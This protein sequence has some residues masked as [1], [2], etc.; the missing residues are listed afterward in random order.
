MPEKQ[1]TYL[2]LEQQTLAQIGRS[3]DSWTAFLELSG[4]LYKYTFSEQL[5]IYAQRPDATACASY[6]IW[7]DTMKRYIK[8]GAKG[9][10]LT[11]DK[12]GQMELRHVFDIADTGTR[13]ISKSP[14][15]WSCEPVHM[16]LLSR[17]LAKIYPGIDIAESFEAQV[18]QCVN[19]MARMYFEAH[20]EDIQQSVDGSLLAGY[21]AANIETKFCEAA[22]V[23]IA[24]TLLSR[25]DLKPKELYVH[26]DFL[27]VFECRGNQM[28]SHLGGA[29]SR[30]SGTLLRQFEGVIKQY[31]KERRNDHEQNNLYTAR[32]LSNSQS[33]SNDTGLPTPAEIR[34]DAKNIPERA[35]SGNVSVSAHHGDAVSTDGR[36]RSGSRQAPGGDDAQAHGSTGSDRRAKTEGSHTMGRENEQHQGTGGGDHPNGA[37]VQLNLFSKELHDI[38]NEDAGAAILPSPAS[39]S[40]SEAKEKARLVPLDANIKTLNLYAKNFRITDD[41]LGA[42]TVSEKFQNNIRAIEMLRQLET[43]SRNAAFEEQEVISKYVG[44]GGLSQYFR[45]D[46]KEYATLK[47]LLTDTEYASAR[48]SA[49]NAHYTSPT[50]IRA[51]YHAVKIMGFRTGN[52]LDPSCGTGNF[53]GLL[54]ESMQNSKLY[55]IELDSI[56]G[57]IAKLLYPQADIT[58]SGY[59]KTD[60]RDFYDLAVGNVP[61]GGYQVFDPAYN[62][63]KFNIHDYFFAKTL[64]QVRPGG[65]IAFITSHYTMDKK[66]IGVR[67]YMAQRAKLLGAIRL[68]NNAFKE[69]AGTQVTSDI[70]F[71]QKREHAIEIDAPWIHLDHT[72]DDIPINS[73]F[74]D[75]PEMML[76]KMSLQNTLYGNDA[77]CE[78]I[79]G[80]VLSQQLEHAV[81][82]ISGKYEAEFDTEL[83]EV[84]NGSSVTMVPANPN[85]RNYSYTVQDGEVYYRENSHMYIPSV[86]ETVKARIQG[87]VSLRDCVRRLIDQQLEEDCSDTEIEETQK[88][89]HSLYDAYTEKYGLINSRGNRLAFSEDSSYYLLCAMEHLDEHGQ[90]ERKADLFYKRTISPHKIITHV[91]TAS[92]ALAVSISDRASVDLT[93]MSELT[94]KNAEDLID[95]LHHVIFP[96]PHTQNEAGNFLYVTADAYLSGN[97]REKLE[98]ARGAAKVDDRFS[99]NVTALEAVL[100]KDLTAAEIEV[101]LGATWIPKEYMQQFM[102][103]TFKTPWYQ[104]NSIRLSYSQ[105]TAEWNISGK[106]KSRGDITAN[107]VYGTERA[108]AYR[109]LE[110]T[111]NLRDV[112]IY[113]TT[114]VDGREKR[115]LNQ[116]ETMLAKQRQDMLKEA[117]RQWIWADSDRRH[118]LTRLYNDNFNSIRPREYNGDHLTFY[119]MN[120]EIELRPHQRAAIA[121][122]LYGGNTLLAHEVGAGKTFEVIA[123]AMEGKRLGLCHKSLI[124]VP[125]HL[126]EQWGAE[127][128]RLYPNANILVV[129]K[130][131]FQTENR[132]KFIARIATGDYDAVIIGHSQFERIPVSKERQEKYL[133]DQIEEIAT[134]IQELKAQDAERFTIKQ[135]EQTKKSTEV[136]LQKLLD[137]PKDDVVTFEQ[138]GVDRLF[139]DEAQHYKNLF[140]YTKMRNVAG[141]STSD[142][143]KSSDMFLKCRYMDEK[144][145]GRGIIFATGTPVSNSM[146]ELYTMQRYLQHDT[147]KRHGLLHFDCWASTFGETT[148]AIELAPEGTGYRARTRFSKFHNLP[149][150]MYMFRETADIKMADQLNLPR[151]EA[152]FHT[153]VAKPTEHQKDMVQDLSERARLVHAGSV[154]SSTDNML[155]ITSDGRK[156]GLDQRLINPMLPDD[157]ESK[158]NLCVENVKRIWDEGSAERLTQLIFCDIATPKKDGSFNV[159]DDIREKLVAKGIP[160]EQ[161]AFIHEAN[162]DIQKKELFAKVRQGSVRVLIGSTGKCGAGMN[163]QDRLIASHDL[164]CPWRPGDLTQR[165]GRTIR[166]GNRNPTVHI[167]RYVTDGTFDSYLW[168]TVEKKQEFIS[169]IMTSKNPVRSCEDADEAALS[170]AEIKALCA[171]NPLV[172]EKMDLD[173]EVS[174]LRLLQSAHMNNQHR[175]EDAVQSIP[176]QIAQHQDSIDRMKID[177]QKIKNAPDMFSMKIGD[178]TFYD[179]KEAGTAIIEA[180][181]THVDQ[182][183]KDIGTYQG[184]PISI[185]FNHF[186]KEHTLSLKGAATYGVTLGIDPRGN[187]TRMDHVLSSLADR[188]SKA[189]IALET[190]NMQLDAAKKELG[191][192][193]PE[194]AVLTQKSQRLTELNLM[195]Q[196]EEQ[197]KNNASTSED[198]PVDPAHKV[199]AL[200]RLQMASRSLPEAKSLPMERGER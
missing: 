48:A 68:P 154:D 101:R 103:E 161:V 8:R 67:Q 126:T 124:T 30:A 53:F 40:M 7:T 81:A 136:R 172:R 155:C 85:V 106:S 110:D 182:S 162:T 195:L 130:K 13:K 145:N 193:F 134:G 25:C 43:K 61:F 16:P 128:M 135:L 132:K 73:Y 102:Y 88:T 12:G 5:L 19:H 123:S 69:N 84:Q 17:A 159:Y 169:Q 157:P 115:V 181:K 91:E 168:Q 121:Q 166:Q 3:Y 170:Y 100:P 97:I 58:I 51:I 44:W 117:F 45:E 119:G 37:G 150:L 20:R 160:K 167:Y 141:L 151:P 165:A 133:I 18:A 156:L 178:A 90:L 189:S 113:D 64:D 57:R 112:R 185:R 96:L 152:V 31:E 98:L 9:I 158:L 72:E 92:D 82:Q 147:L 59:E 163:V 33:G 78:P 180:C 196:L 138:M 21:D 93:F 22:S 118:T 197:E 54:P 6:A 131:D 79:E 41:H 144:T 32:A 149:E 192:P 87:M 62:R 27:S 24:Y 140:L 194:E 34:Q 187:I 89:L 71:L 11:V 10:A 186:L 94:G 55:G 77:T 127:F 74:M 60:R 200:K 173:I 56:T 139:V 35:S 2:E 198:I 174:R 177:I 49:L 148:T 176:V 171:G 120:P 29:V 36:N 183:E 125:N 175:L 164:D 105:I 111:L 191:K 47:Q 38:K 23:S 26:E 153:V 14:H 4:R 188:L 65:I 109:I 75:H 76:G 42:G 15:L 122:T 99:S 199:S 28:L 39:F 114:R 83:G 52:I 190:A 146:T 129:T 179:K 66:S 116:K 95:E 143:Q 108:N 46:H 1:S 86:S 80:A 137:R 104:Q 63:L 107:A 184:F 142:A 50:V 70:L